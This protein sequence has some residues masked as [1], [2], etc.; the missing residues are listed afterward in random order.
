MQRRDY[1]HGKSR[2]ILGPGLH[3]AWAKGGGRLGP[4]PRLAEGR[5]LDYEVGY[6][7]ALIG[8][9]AVISSLS[10][11]TTDS[12]QVLKAAVVADGSDT[13]RKALEPFGGSVILV[14]PDR[15]LIGAASS[16]AEVEALVRHVTESLQLRRPGM[17]EDGKLP[18]SVR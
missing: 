4:Q 10:R 13:V 8:D 7:F 18:L 3:P 14:R 9:P 5:L 17:R 16:A 11:G 6:E 15:Y 2:P 1:E 12:L